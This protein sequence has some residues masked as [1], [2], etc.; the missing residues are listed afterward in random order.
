MQP[1]YQYTEFPKFYLAS[2]FQIAEKCHTCHM[3]YMDIHMLP[4]TL[5]YQGDVI[6]LQ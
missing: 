2:F 1:V 5:Y 6:Y 4:F 3:P